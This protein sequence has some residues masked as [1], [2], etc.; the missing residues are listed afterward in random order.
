MVLETEILF[1]ILAV[2]VLTLPG[3]DNVGREKSSCFS[4]WSI[5][6]P[7]CYIH[8]GQSNHSPSPCQEALMNATFIRQSPIYIHTHRYFYI[9][10][11]IKIFFYVYICTHICICVYLSVECGG[12]KSKEPAVEIDVCRNVG[13]AV[14]CT[15]DLAGLAAFGWCLRPH[16]TSE[17]N[18][19]SFPGLYLEWARDT[20]FMV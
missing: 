20:V 13:G 14:G 19:L 3:L 12:S 5:A 17:I 7:D 4:G 9:Y 18:C 10:Q 15:V 1:H 16:E 2:S 6:N 8:P 11:Y